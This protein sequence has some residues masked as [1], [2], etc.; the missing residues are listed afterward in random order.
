MDMVEGFSLALK[1]AK[2]LRQE[3]MNERTDYTCYH[4]D[5]SETFSLCEH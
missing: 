3:L 5:T 2:V 1:E 4:E